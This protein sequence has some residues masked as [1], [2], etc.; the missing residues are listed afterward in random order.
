ML[1]MLGDRC[2]LCHGC[3]LLSEMASAVQAKPTYTLFLFTQSN[4]RHPIF[5]CMRWQ[6]MTTMISVGT[7]PIGLIRNSCIT[8]R[9]LRLGSSLVIPTLGF[10]PWAALNAPE[11]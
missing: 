11:Y 4:L 5:N 7:I 8:S 10:V 9:I 3:K 6:R 2:N 1:V